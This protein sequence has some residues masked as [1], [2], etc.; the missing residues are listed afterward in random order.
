M[1]VR[2]PLPSLRIVLSTV[3][4]LIC[5]KEKLLQLHYVPASSSLNSTTLTSSQLSQGDIVHSATLI[6]HTFQVTIISSF[7]AS[8][9]LEKS[10]NFHKKREFSW[11]NLFFAI[12]LLG[13]QWV[14]L[15][16]ITISIKKWPEI[17]Y[18]TYYTLHF[19]LQIFNTEN[20][21]QHIAPIDSTVSRNECKA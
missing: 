7:I 2:S 9:L 11:T 5:R 19:I 1:H 12:S 21:L 18:Y 10:F 20:S 16:L 6:R 13:N 3:H 14:D 15:T 8:L 4:Y 17:P